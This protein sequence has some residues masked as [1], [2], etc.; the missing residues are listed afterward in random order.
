MKKF[1]Q[2]SDQIARLYPPEKATTEDGQKI[3][4]Q[5]ITFQVTDDC[6]LACTYCYQGHKGKNKMSFETAK[7]FFDLV[8]SG[9]KG[10]KSYINPEKS[11]GL[12]V[13]FIGGEPLL[14][15]ELIDQICTYIMDTLIKLNHPW[16]MKTMF[17]ICSNGVLYRDEKVQA[18]LRKWAHRILLL[19]VIRSFMIHAEFSQTADLVMILLLMLLQIG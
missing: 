15:V 5:S 17:S 4:T 16:A 1:E 8:L 14:E 3:L 11:P 18:F 10:F 6:N 19:M 13:D 2:Y 9:D 7:K 12:V